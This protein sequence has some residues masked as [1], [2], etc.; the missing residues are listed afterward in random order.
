MENSWSEREIAA[1]YT[2]L[3]QKH[4]RLEIKHGRE[5]ESLENH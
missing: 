5:L 1:Q 3:S 4:T 2:S